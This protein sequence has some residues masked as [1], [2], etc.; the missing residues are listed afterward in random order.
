MFEIIGGKHQ[1][2]KWP[3]NGFR[4]TVPAG[5]VPKGTTISLAVRALLADGIE[6]PENC[7]LISA[8]YWIA[9]SQH[10]DEDVTLHMQHCAIIHSTVECSKFKIIAGRC[11]QPKFPYQL[12]KR[13]GGVFTPH[14]HEASISIKQFSFYGAAQEGEE[15]M[16][17]YYWGQGFYRQK[18]QG[19]SWILDYTITCFVESLVTVSRIVMH[20]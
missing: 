11:N 8:I 18:V 1:S 17:S 16:S 15:D 5:A 3:G 4:L 14:S 13:E 19:Q 12:K 10:F 6:L 2:I 9:A 20:S 7:R